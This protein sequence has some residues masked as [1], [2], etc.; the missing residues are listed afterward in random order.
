MN[1]NEI[2]NVFENKNEVSQKRKEFWENA[3]MVKT[4]KE[5]DNK[6][7]FKV[8]DEQYPRNDVVSTKFDWSSFKKGLNNLGIEYT[9]K[10]VQHEQDS[11]TKKESLI[12]NSE[13]QIQ[14]TTDGQFDI[15]RFAIVDKNNKPL[16][17]GRCFDVDF[18]NQFQAEL[19][20]A[21]KA[22]WVAEQ[23]KNQQ[24][25][26]SLVLVLNTDNEALTYQTK[27]EQKGFILTKMCSDKNIGLVVNHIT[28]GKKNPAD[29]FVRGNGYAKFDKTVDYKDLLET[30]EYKDDNNEVVEET[31]A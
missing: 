26:D 4:L 9:S 2:K 11:L 3:E 10:E 17:Y 19:D 14:L 21:K 30:N 1:Q 24:G 20:A 22:V 15:K 23:I 16:W 27:K 29:S 5:L 18:D 13:Y 31:E 12:E 28:G 6:G 7:L 25:L 8:F